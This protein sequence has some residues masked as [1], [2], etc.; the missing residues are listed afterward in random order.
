MPAPLLV[1]SFPRL[2]IS[3][4]P[5]PISFPVSVPVI[6]VIAASRC[7]LVH[8]LGALDCLLWVQLNR[9]ADILKVEVELV[10]KIEKSLGIVPLEF[11]L[12]GGQLEY[13]VYGSN[14][15][16][17]VANWLHRNALIGVVTRA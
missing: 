15:V 17:G 3:V 4:I 14:S 5:A 12:P 8:R 16:S 6:A 11:L 1:V 2:L 10:D 9:R 7:R 13:Y